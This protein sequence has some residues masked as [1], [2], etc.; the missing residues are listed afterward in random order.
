MPETAKRSIPFL[1]QLLDFIYP[2][3]CPE[4]TRPIRA[5]NLKASTSS[6]QNNFFCADCWGAIRRIEGARCPQCA[7]PFPAQSALSHSPGHLCGD[8]RSAP[9]DFSRAVTP[10]P[11][12]GA[13]AKAIQRLK[14]QQQHKLVQ[15]IAD[16]L[17][18]DLEGLSVDW[19]M[20]IPLHP[21][22]LRSREFNQSLLLAKVLAQR[23]RLPLGIDLIRRIRE[24]PPQVG[25]SKKERKKNMH[26]AFSVVAPDTIAGRRILLIDDVF[27]TGAT[28]REAAKTLKK[29]DAKEIIVATPARM[30]L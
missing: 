3:S 5:G 29:A 4:C 25:L 23:L 26:R 8:C 9:P 2:E 16:L 27:T 13:V 20:A 21:R 28:L 1:D 18:K 6:L 17:F 10:Y 7:E 12:E 24:T 14:Y 11:Y 15:S 30:I 22:R 19:V